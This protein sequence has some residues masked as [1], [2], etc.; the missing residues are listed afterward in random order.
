[1]GVSNRHLEHGQLADDML[2]GCWAD[3]GESI[4]RLLRASSLIAKRGAKKP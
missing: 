3:C 4:E 1:M 2:R